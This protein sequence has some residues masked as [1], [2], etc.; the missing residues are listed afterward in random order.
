MNELKEL[1]TKAEE[2]AK[3]IQWNEEWIRLSIVE[4]TALMV[5]GA[6]GNLDDARVLF[7]DIKKDIEW[8][9]RILQNNIFLL[10]EDLAK[11]IQALKLEL[12]TPEQVAE[13][14]QAE[15]RRIARLEMYQV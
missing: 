11:R 12:R 7:M 6:K 1:E 9:Q 14:K 4:K 5:A 15:E 10:K 8:N 13:D 3:K 2:Y